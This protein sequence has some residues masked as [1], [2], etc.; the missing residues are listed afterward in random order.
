MNTEIAGSVPQKNSL[1]TGRRGFTLIELLVVIS[2][3]A[4]L[5]AILFPAFA[6]VRDNARRS[7]CQSNLKQLGLAIHQYTQDYDE[8]MPIVVS[9]GADAALCVSTGLGQYNGQNNH[10]GWI[11]VIF[12]YVKNSQI[13]VC[14]SDAQQ[15][16]KKGS[17]YAMNRYLGWTA[18]YYPTQL[19]V[20]L[21]C[22]NSLG[23]YCGDMPYNLSAI[24]PASEKILLSEFGQ[25]AQYT[26]TFTSYRAFYSSIPLPGVLGAGANFPSLNMQS[27]STVVNVSATHNGTGTFLF[28]DGHVK[29]IVS[30]LS[31][32]SV[33][34]STNEWIP[35]SNAA[36]TGWDKHWLPD[37]D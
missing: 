37:Q 25:Y 8:K 29:N 2:I 3:I 20:A 31:S 15:V 6:R 18:S 28:V 36:G 5:A 7:T 21:P 19:N 27:T 17:S 22:Y 16:I 14:P 11:E 30:T 12:P 35:T 24:T 1:H 32:N 33:P 10:W 26:A 34:A 23:N 4:L 9:Q 13:F